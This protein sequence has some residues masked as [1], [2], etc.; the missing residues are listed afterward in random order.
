[1]KKSRMCVISISALIIIVCFC[2]AYQ[3]NTYF[4]L[5]GLYG[6]IYG[7]YGLGLYGGLESLL[8]SPTIMTTSP[9]VTQPAV[10]PV[11]STPGATAASSGLVPFW[12]TI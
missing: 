5:M 11:M 7:L 4:G 6:G 1:M 10:I 3:A 8:S 9:S 12:I 2:F